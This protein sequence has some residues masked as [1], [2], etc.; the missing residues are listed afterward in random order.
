MR[1]AKTFVSVL[2]KMIGQPLSEGNQFMLDKYMSASFN[3]N[4]PI[5]KTPETTWDINIVLDYLVKLGSNEDILD[6]NILGGKVVLLLLLSQMCRSGDLL[7]LKLSSLSLKQGAVSFVLQKPTKT[8]NKSTFS[9]SEKL[10]HMTVKAFGE[11]PLLCP[12]KALYVKKTRHRRGGGPPICVGHIQDTPPCFKTDC[13]WVKDI[14]T[15]TGLGQYTVHSTRSASSSLAVL[16]GLSLDQIVSRVSWIWA[17]TFTKHYWKA[18][19]CSK[20]QVD[21]HGFSTVLANISPKSKPKGISS[22]V[23]VNT[24]MNNALKW[25]EENTSNK[26]QSPPPA[27]SRKWGFPCLTACNHP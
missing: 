14:M 24:T 10:Q 13:H 6:C 25:S 5:K 23:V 9:R 12:L 4:P 19:E 15:K 18:R 3:E 21:K 22:T 7:Q 2:R 17:S 16:M 1:K 26:G 20:T 8:F 27:R 11:N